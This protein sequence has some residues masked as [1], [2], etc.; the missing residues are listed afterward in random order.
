MNNLCLRSCGILLLL[1]FEL[2][3]AD[4]SNCHTVKA[5]WHYDSL[6]P[7][8]G[9]FHDPSM[10]TQVQLKKNT[11]RYIFAPDDPNGYLC[12]ISWNKLY[13][14]SR[15]GRLHLHHEDSDRFVWRRA[16]ECLIFN[17]SYVVG[18]KQNCSLQNM[19]QIAAYAYD[20]GN[21]PFENSSLLH[22]FSTYLEVE[23]VYTLTLDFLPTSAVYALWDATGTQ[24]LEKQV[25]QHTYCEAYQEGYVLSW[26]F[27]G[28]CP[29]PQDVSACYSDPQA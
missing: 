20:L 19:I 4:P 21:K 14:G 1:L 13:G 24:L 11:A 15:C 3:R 16:S 17:G 6:V 27:G 8:P 5:G 2:G 22:E 12:E 9:G 23:S 28:E 25:I 18:E 7:I 26:Y 10:T 29:A